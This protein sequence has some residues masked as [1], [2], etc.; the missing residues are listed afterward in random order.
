MRKPKLVYLLFI[1]LFLILL[2][3]PLIVKNTYYR[4]LFDQTLIN[5]IVVLG[6]NFITGLTGQM[7]LGTAGIFGIGAYTSALL[8][9]Q[10][11]I[12]PWLSLI[13]AILMGYLIG[14]ILGWPS[15]RIKGI[16][17]AL[18]TIG[19]GEIIRLLLTN[20]AGITG[21]TQ[22]VLNIPNYTLFNIDIKD[23]KSIYYLLLAIT[24]IMT[25]IA[26]KIINSKWGRVL[27]A[28]RDNDQAVESCGINI[29]EIKIKAFLLCT[30]YGCI[31]G[32]LY[33]H[34]MGYINP[35][36]FTFDLSIKY[37]MMLMLGGI[38]SIPG[39][40]LGAAIVTLLPEFLRF[41]QDYYWLI[42]SSVLLVIVILLPNGVISLFDG[43]SLPKFTGLFQQKNRSSIRGKQ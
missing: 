6:L 28:I 17:L 25:L 18:T 7:N 24:V 3:L 27:K 36:D 40:I 1:V 8:T 21:G 37:L 41:L 5:I 42:F 14:V 33:A 39:N 20:M 2:I 23:E 11:H 29:A 43:L 31:A 22:G 13:A 12:S 34:L 10:L 4:M 35:A 15:L 16:Y 32:A 19:F 30:V 9:T 38:G 26:L